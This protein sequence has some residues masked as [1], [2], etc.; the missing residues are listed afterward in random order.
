MN[1]YVSAHSYRRWELFH[2]FKN[3]KSLRVKYRT[4]VTEIALREKMMR[5]IALAKGE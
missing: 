5:E 2:L 1:A 3:Y 4:G